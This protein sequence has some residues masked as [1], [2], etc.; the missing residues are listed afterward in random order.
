V[1]AGLGGELAEIR[2][3]DGT[4]LSTTPVGADAL[5]LTRGA[6]WAASFGGQLTKVAIN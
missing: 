2:S 3:K 6:V 5:A 1:W 4:V